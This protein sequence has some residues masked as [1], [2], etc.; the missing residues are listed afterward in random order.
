LPLETVQVEFSWVEN[1]RLEIL[2]T[3]GCSGKTGVEMEAMVGATLAAL[4]VYDMCK[5]S[6]RELCI[7]RVELVRKSGGASGEFVRGQ[8]S[9]EAKSGTDEVNE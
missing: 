4:T 3:T 9:L 2:V 6:D 7:E 1:D 8:D 5:S